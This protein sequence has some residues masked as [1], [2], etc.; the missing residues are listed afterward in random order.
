[1]GPNKNAQRGRTDGLTTYI[2][3]NLNGKIL[4]Q[5]VRSLR[6]NFNKVRDLTLDLKTSPEVIAMQEVWMPHQW[7]Q[8]LNGY[9]PLQV[10]ERK[11]RIVNKGGGVG[12]FIKKHIQYVLLDK[13]ITADLEYIAIKIHNTTIFNIYRPP[14]GNLE[15]YMTKL[16]DILQKYANNTKGKFIIGGDF[17]IDFLNTNHK[18][19]TETI[20]A[21]EPFGLANKIFSPTRITENSQTMIDAIFC[22]DST[23]IGEVIITDISDHL[24]LAIAL[25]KTKTTTDGQDKRTC[26]TND[27][28]KE[29]LEKLKAQLRNVNWSP[30][31]DSENPCKD[32]Q[33]IFDTFFNLF[34]PKITRWTNKNYHP[35]MPW[36]TR[37]IMISRR[38]K[39]QLYKVA[40]KTKNYEN[41]KTYRTIYNKTIKAAKYLYL[42]NKINEKA[43]NGKE[44]WKLTNNF[45]N[46]TREPNERISK[47]VND[48]KVITN[49][50]KIC[51]A[52]N[53]FFCTVGEKLA[54]K[55]KTDRDTGG[56]I[57]DSTISQDKFHFV[58]TNEAEI[59][60]IITRMKPKVSTGYDNISNFIIKQL[61][62]ELSKPITY[63][64]NHAI[65]TKKFPDEW[66]IAKIV[67]LFKGKG[68]KEDTSN[69]RPI[70]LL[71]TCSKIIEKV[72]EKQLREYLDSNNIITDTQF[73]FRAGHQISHI[74]MAAQDYITE[75]RNSKE[76]V[77]AVF[78]DLRKAFDSVQH[79]LLLQKIKSTGINTEL[80]NSYLQ[81]RKQFTTI[82]SSK[83]KQRT[84]KYGVP[85]GSI[86][87][88]LLFL[89]YIN[90]LPTVIPGKTLLFAD[91][92]SI[93]IKGKNET[94]LINKT[95]STLKLAHTWFVRNGL[96][97]HTGKTNFM[98]F[99]D[100]DREKY[101]NKII[102]DNAKIK[103][104][105]KEE[106]EKSIKFIGIHIDENLDWKNHINYITMKVN[107][108]LHVITA[109][110]HIFPLKIRK[111]LYSA[112]I[113]P[114]LEMGIEAW[115]GKALNK[116]MTLQKKCIRH[117]AG[118][119]NYI[120]HSTPLLYSLNTLNFKDIYENKLKLLG[121][122]KINATIPKG[123]NNLLTTNTFNTRNLRRIRDFI[124]PT[125]KTDKDRHTPR[126]NTPRLWNKLEQEFKEL[127]SEKKFKLTMKRK[128]I[129]NYGN[130]IC[131]ISHCTS[132]SNHRPL[133]N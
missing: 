119:K 16:K 17:N 10:I 112:F 114:Y 27:I 115:G 6:G 94:E 1:M 126:Y 87:G 58:E 72:M 83:S 77:M 97:I 117:V 44:I 53:D 48:T 45:I 88:P 71:P 84:I 50:T 60:K 28:R 65:K 52:F 59:L 61:K 18:Y 19:V 82:G 63:I 15:I 55:L 76:K 4:F 102:L 92:A 37:G 79:K 120:Y 130:F 35:K 25:D 30:I 40:I 36:I 127:D 95:N 62:Y 123:I 26:W 101:N 67:P 121:F 34:C 8:T 116:M 93:F 47:I 73:G 131:K 7:Q 133:W 113:R 54:K 24:G 43:G 111:A 29:N 110:K 11:G 57:T 90:N 23:K 13:E 122:K 56:E 118:V 74:I 80:L 91:D 22:N 66:K 99:N 69:Y 85:Q 96:T 107:S 41:F 31:I 14:S 68:S 5:N 46:K 32:F 70:S 104:I 125:T 103:R 132:C 100:T 49:E 3:S 124:N 2:D 109:N 42:Q 38:K 20:N 39:M 129:E 21:M 128:C 108:N 81:N 98:V 89:L 105:G 33:D 9:Q 51:E 86:L 75:A 12:M 64:I 106:K 78:M